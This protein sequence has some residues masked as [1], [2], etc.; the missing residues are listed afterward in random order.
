[1]LGALSQ[2][3]LG[4]PDLMYVDRQWQDVGSG[5]A[6]CRFLWGYPLLRLLPLC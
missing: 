5:D 4:A 1:M 6:R 2:A 3:A